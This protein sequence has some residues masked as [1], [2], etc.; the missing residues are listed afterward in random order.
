[1][2]GTGECCVT[3]VTAAR[4]AA[5]MAVLSPAQHLCPRTERN[6]LSTHAHCCVHPHTDSCL[7]CRHLPQSGTRAPCT[8]P[9][10]GL[11]HW[12]AALQ[13]W[14]C[15]QHCMPSLEAELTASIW[16]LTQMLS[17]LTRTLSCPQSGTKAGS[18]LWA[19][20][21]SSSFHGLAPTRLTRYMVTWH[22]AQHAL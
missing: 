11:R 10:P 21:K 12:P 6:A 18:L 22:H 16:A 15:A 17:P 4:L 13:S 2:Q 20:R 19:P 9:R 3:P 7:S 14:Q 5:A 1:M 8:K